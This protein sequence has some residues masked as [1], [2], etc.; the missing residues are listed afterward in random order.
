MA[1]GSFP[2]RACRTFDSAKNASLA[3]VSLNT[4]GVALDGGAS[5]MDTGSTHCVALQKGLASAYALFAVAGYPPGSRR[6][7]AAYRRE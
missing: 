5:D 1:A 6:S 2:A 3:A 7:W 4:S